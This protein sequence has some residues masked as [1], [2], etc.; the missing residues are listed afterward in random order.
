MNEKFVIPRNKRPAI[1]PKTHGAN[2]GNGKVGDRRI[3][4]S[5]KS[6]TDKG[7]RRNS[8][9]VCAELRIRQNFLTCL[10]KKSAQRRLIS[11]RVVDAAAWIQFRHRPWI[12]PGGVMT[13]KSR[14]ELDD[15]E[16][17]T[18]GLETALGEFCKCT[19]IIV[20]PEIEI[21][22]AI[23]KEVDGDEPAEKVSERVDMF[24]TKAGGNLGGG[25][26]GQQSRGFCRVVWAVDAVRND[27]KAVECEWNV[28]I[29]GRFGREIHGH[30]PTVPIYHNRF[31]LLS[32]LSSGGPFF[33][34]FRIGR[35][36][37]F[38]VWACGETRRRVRSIRPD[39]E[40]VHVY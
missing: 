36:D 15:D 6:S 29:V 38:C 24:V 31:R 11:N 17:C 21:H 9:Q 12:D 27:G 30:C 4:E 8:D 25:R 26:T 7:M 1:I 22:N 37:G 2:D 19:P 32:P 39:A 16:N 18:P 10:A 14:N 40:V 20:L 28:D 13:A 34:L 23:S 5:E 3:V 35:R 33:E